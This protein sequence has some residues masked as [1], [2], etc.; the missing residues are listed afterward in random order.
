MNEEVS[1]KRGE[2]PVLIDP[3][4]EDLLCEFFFGKS[5]QEAES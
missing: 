1:E 2:K 5:T 3:C 4:K